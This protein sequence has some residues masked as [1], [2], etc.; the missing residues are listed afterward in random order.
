MSKRNRS[1][2][3]LITVIALIIVGIISVPLLF[4]SFGEKQELTL[5]IKDLQVSAE[6]PLFAGSNT[7][8]A[9]CKP[10]L[11][12]WLSKND[13]QISDLFEARLKRAVVHLPD[14][15][16]PVK[17]ESVSLLFA[18]DQ[19]D[20]QTVGVLNP[21]PEGA[22]VLELNI[23]EEQAQGRLLLI[24]PAFS[25]V[26]DCVISDDLEQDLILKTDLE[27]SMIVHK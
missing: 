4:M 8:Q 16:L 22:R 18:S 26:L 17:I 23:A 25:V 10:E 9:I 11:N 24:Q 15:T 5:S 6:A 21:V 2:A 27:F 7:A 19:M 13:L 14:T 12:E 1:L 20:M 3:I